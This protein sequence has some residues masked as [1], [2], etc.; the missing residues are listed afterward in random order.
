MSCQKADW[1]NHKGTCK[2]SQARNFLF[3]AGEIAHHTFYVYREKVFDEF[4][5]S[6]ERNKDHIKTKDDQADKQALLSC[7]ACAD[8]LAYMHGLVKSLLR[9]EWIPD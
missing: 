3:R 8:A 7:W 5:L 9:G 1:N 2:A 6:V 4:V